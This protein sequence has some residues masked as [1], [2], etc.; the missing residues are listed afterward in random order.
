MQPALTNRRTITPFMP[1]PPTEK[2][3]YTLASTP[4]ATHIRTVPKPS[5]TKRG[6]TKSNFSTSAGFR[7][8]AA[9]ALQT[10]QREPRICT[11]PGTAGNNQR[12]PEE[13]KDQRMV[14]D[15]HARAQ[16]TDQVRQVRTTHGTTTPPAVKNSRPARCH[17]DT[18][19]LR[20]PR[21][22]KSLDF[23][24]NVAPPETQCRSSTSESYQTVSRGEP[25]DTRDHGD[26]G[27]T[28]LSV[29]T[30]VSG[31]KNGD[32]GVAISSSDQFACDIQHEIT[33]RWTTKDQM[34]LA[35]E[36]RKTSSQITREETTVSAQ[37]GRTNSAPHHIH[38]RP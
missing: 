16:T 11:P 5:L 1:V 19:V 13:Y 9:A 35:L 7:A 23:E 8:K 6:K 20:L 29:N 17:R 21:D 33:S 18:E 32:A 4:P 34:P 26:G 30:G 36:Q 37:H 3:V 24:L 28:R 14:E 2:Q 10:T 15:E 31:E 27:D 12:K 38:R 22:D 25:D